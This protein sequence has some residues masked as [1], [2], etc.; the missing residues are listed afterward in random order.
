MRFPRTHFEKWAHAIRVF[1]GNKFFVT[2]EPHIEDF[3]AQINASLDE[4]IAN[5]KGRQLPKNKKE[6]FAD[7]AFTWGDWLL[8]GA[9]TLQGDM[10]SIRRLIGML[11]SEQSSADPDYSIPAL[12]EQS[13]NS[14]PLSIVPHAKEG[15]AIRRETGKRLYAMNGE[16]NIDGI[17]EE[18]LIFLHDFNWCGKKMFHVQ[19]ALTHELALT[20]I[21]GVI[22][23]F[24]KPPFQT[25]CV[26]FPHNESVSI[27]GSPIRYAYV[28][29]YMEE[30]GRHIHVMYVRDKGLPFFHEFVFDDNKKLGTQIREQI[31]A[32]YAGLRQAI[33]ENINAFSLLGALLLYMNSTER[34]I[35]EVRPVVLFRRK[36]SALPCCHVG[37]SI[38]INK[39]LYSA[40]DSSEG[41]R[42]EHLT[43]VLKW[44]V[45][46][47]F[48][49]QAC[50]EGHKERQI[51]WVRP[52]LKGRERSNAAV[53]MKPVSYEVND[54][55]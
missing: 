45:R 36:D 27:L 5:A 54:I 49:N 14:M 51:T 41:E 1:I 47:H 9:E 37:G 30:D 8:S 35:K 17:L 6:D 48:R 44:A 33:H 19:G 32:R 43:H 13:S 2:E 28:S 50:G 12:S 25:I 23:E 53:P 11:K 21:E 16:D 39:S 55:P 38:S 20:H 10:Q 4:A 34:D 24:F 46:G 40:P 29:E 22:A 52:Y 15:P 3:R 31:G 18:M 26:H 7:A 42:A